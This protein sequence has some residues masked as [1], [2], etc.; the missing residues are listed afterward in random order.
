MSETPLTPEQQ[1]ELAGLRKALEEEFAGTEKEKSAQ[2]A[3]KDLSDLKVD[4]LNAMKHTLAHGQNE[5]NKVNLAKW[6]YDKLL[7]EGKA[8][9]DPLKQLI[10]GMPAPTTVPTPEPLTEQADAD[11]A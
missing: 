5:T 11:P 7:E 9:T 3:R 1:Q 2:S 4:A 6:V 8:D 10:A